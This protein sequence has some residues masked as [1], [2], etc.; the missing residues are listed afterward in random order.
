M[1]AA[2]A[3]FCWGFAPSS[4]EDSPGY[5]WPEEVGVSELRSGA[6]HIRV[7]GGSGLQFGIMLFADD[8]HLQSIAMIRV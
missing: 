2:C 3:M 4:D 5:F 8:V 1:L 6:G 7:E